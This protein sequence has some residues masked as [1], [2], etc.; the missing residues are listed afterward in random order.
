[1]LGFKPTIGANWY[2]LSQLNFGL[3]YYH[4][5]HDYIY[6]NRGEHGDTEPVSRLSAKAE[7]YHR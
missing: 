3:Q 7:F 5:I 6:S 2:P 4:E 1:M